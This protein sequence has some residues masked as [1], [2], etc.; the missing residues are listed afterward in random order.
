[1][2]ISYPIWMALPHHP[3]LAVWTRQVSSTILCFTAKILPLIISKAS[4]LG[5]LAEAWKHAATTSILEGQTSKG[6]NSRQNKWVP[7]T[8][9]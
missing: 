1:M 3:N 4:M 5:G 6:P 7:G 8:Y 9:L 2:Q